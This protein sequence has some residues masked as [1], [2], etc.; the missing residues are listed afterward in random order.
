MFYLITII[1]SLILWLWFSYIKRVREIYNK[2]VKFP[3]WLYILGFIFL[4]IPFLNFG[5]PCIFTLCIIF[6]GD[7][8]L[9]NGKQSIGEKIKNILCK[10]F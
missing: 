4:F 1:F 3:V 6:D 9:K 7:F 8:K 5:F 2:P 10:E